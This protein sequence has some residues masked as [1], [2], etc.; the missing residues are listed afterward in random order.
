LTAIHYDIAGEGLPFVLLHGIGSNSKS[1]RRQLPAFSAAYKVVAWDAPGFGKSADPVSPVPSMREYTESLRALFDSLGFASAFVLGHSLGGI[2]A[3]DFYR[4]YPERVRALILADTTQ[5]GAAEDVEVRESKLAKRLE[6][7]RRMSPEQLAKERAPALLSSRATKEM[8]E[9]AIAIMSEVRRVGY[10]FASI[11]M[12]TADERGVLDN[13]TFPL[14]MLWGEEDQITPVWRT[15]PQSAQ[16]ETIRN[17]GHL[18]YLEQAD[19][20]NQS[21]LRFLEECCKKEGSS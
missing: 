21:V 18:C 13:I 7:I 11:A 9:E 4:I 8:L 17:A 12:A 20:F 6:M 19:T 5:G 10:E 14:L 16:V 2:I 15:W 1:W 3:Q